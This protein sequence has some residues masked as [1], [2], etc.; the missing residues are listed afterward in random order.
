MP[1]SHADIPD[2][3][4]KRL[5]KLIT[6]FT[7][8]PSLVLTNLFGSDNWD[9]DVIK[10]ESQIGNRGLTPFVAPDSESPRVAPLG[11][12]QH[13]AKTAS[14]KEKMYLGESFL[15]NLRAP[16]TTATYLRTRT[17]LAQET[18]FDPAGFRSC[19]VGEKSFPPYIRRARGLRSAQ[20]YQGLMHGA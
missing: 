1:H 5:T 4:L 14:W 15:N 7:T 3:R 18:P 12:A 19:Q 10:W 17:R 6:R 16:G 9:S 11:I 2:L 13:E 8:A 20:A